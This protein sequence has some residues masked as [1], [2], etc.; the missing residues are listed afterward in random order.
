MSLV[1][2]LPDPESATWCEDGVVGDG[3]SNPGDVDPDGGDIAD[4]WPESEEPIPRQRLNWINK[5]CHRISR[6]WRQRGI[7]PYH[8]DE[9]YPPGARVTYGDGVVSYQRIGAGNTKG[10]APTDGTKWMRWG[11]TE[12]QLDEELGTPSGALV[13]GAVTPS[14]TSGNPTVDYCRAQRF[15]QSTEMNVFCRL[16][17]AKQQSG[18]WSA[19]LTLSGA[20]AFGSGADGVLATLASQGSNTGAPGLLSASVVN[21]TSVVVLLRTGTL[22]GTDP[23]VVDVMIRGH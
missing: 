19:T 17:M 12:E 21:E 10:T 3:G 5:I 14:S 20:A 7:P 4:G 6:L 18:E 23:V 15:P 2:T 16:T 1:E 13:G 8:V 22:E 11:Y 9:T